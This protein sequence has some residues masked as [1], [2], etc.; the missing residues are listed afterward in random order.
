MW[1]QRSII[2]YSLQKRATIFNFLKNALVFLI[3]FKIGGPNAD[4]LIT[5]AGGIFIAPFF[6]LSS[7]G[8]QM[9]DRFD[10]AKVARWLKFVEIGVAFIAVAGF[11]LRTALQI[12]GARTAEQVAGT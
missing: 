1:S 7:L 8:G 4:A 5:L 11:G 6:F 12:H 2:D 3:L 10:K 9:A